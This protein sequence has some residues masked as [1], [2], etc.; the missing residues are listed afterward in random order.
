MVGLV[1]IYYFFYFIDMKI[2]KL[3]AIDSTNSYLKRLLTKGTVDDLTVVVSKNQTK[4]KG[5]NENIWENEASLNLA[6]SIYKKFNNLDVKDKFMLNVISSLSVFQ[7]LKENN[8]NKISIKWPNDIMT[9]NGKISGILIENSVKGKLINESVI[10]VG[11]N[12]NQKKF[13]KL[14]N[15]TSLLIETG[16]EFS[17]DTLASRL[18]EIFRKKFLQFEKNEEE[19]LE[20]YNNQLFLKNINSNFMGLDNKKFSGK[21]ISVN[22]SGEL[23]IKKTNK[24]EIKYSENTIKFL[25]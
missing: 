22:K 24:E 4:G 17:L 9:V 15:A 7:L 10:G 20:N 21:I 6:F 13:D 25:P 1:Q 2:I 12:V 23:R 3:D 11:I 14:P 16:S 18:V 19:L 8:L 5:R